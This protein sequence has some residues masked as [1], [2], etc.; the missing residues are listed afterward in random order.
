MTLNF[1]SQFLCVTGRLVKMSVCS[2]CSKSE[3]ANSPLATCDKCGIRHCQNCSTLSSTEIRTVILK[4]R[5]MKYYCENCRAE[6]DNIMSC[7]NIVPSGEEAI[8]SGPVAEKSISAQE[9]ANLLKPLYMKIAELEAQVVNL[10]ES[11]ID[12][13]NLLTQKPQLIS[14]VNEKSQD[15]DKLNVQ[16]ASYSSKLLKGSIHGNLRP[17]NSRTKSNQSEG[18]S[19]EE[20]GQRTAPAASQLSATADEFVPVQSRKR[21]KF[22][23]KPTVVGTAEVTPSANA[24]IGRELNDKK[25]WLFI[26]RVKDG[27]NEKIVKDYIMRKTKLDDKDVSVKTIETSY[28]KKDSQCFQVGVKFE[29]KDQLYEEDFW[30]RG[31]AF[32]RYRFRFDKQGSDTNS[33]LGTIQT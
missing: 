12:L 3:S 27:V 14:G 32:R 25:A 33:F 21:N 17:G 23:K 22:V 13:I 29:L 18:S 10:K 30:P 28:E 2:K 1:V 7:H 19:R 31:V 5:I 20:I 4:N 15:K 8:Q 26:S 16:N 6:I 24:F 11:N 9:I